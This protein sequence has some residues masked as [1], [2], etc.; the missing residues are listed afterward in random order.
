M[1]ATVTRSTSSAGEAPASSES[2]V[3]RTCDAAALPAGERSSRSSSPPGTPRKV[4]LMG[5]SATAAA[6]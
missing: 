1:A 2:A 3:R 6:K 5:L 4:A